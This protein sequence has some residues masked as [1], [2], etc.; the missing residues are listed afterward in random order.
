MS[1]LRELPRYRSHKEVQALKIT[2]VVP[3]PR[4]FELQFGPGWVPHLMTSQWVSK[5]SPD[6]TGDPQ[7]LV[8][9]YL[10]VYAE[11]HQ[12]WSP[13]GPFEAGYTLI[14]GD[15]DPRGEAALDLGPWP[16]RPTCHDGDPMALGT[17]AVWR[18]PND[19]GVRTCSF[20]GCIHPADLIRVLDEG[21]T[22][23]CADWKYG[24]PHKF[25]VSGGS[26]GHGKWYNNHLLELT[27]E[28]FAILAPRLVPGPGVVFER[29]EKGVKYRGVP[30]RG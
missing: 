14:A 10:V 3:S 26:V 11:G 22:L 8:G 4:G 28:A 21:A 12:S 29:D 25:Y 13:V 2:A 16:A 20:C 1:I 6:I 7:A 19:R 24:W 18:K 5:H 15:P 9:G 23:E 30:P 17:Q 27:P